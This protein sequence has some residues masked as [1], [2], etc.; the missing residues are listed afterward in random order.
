MVY[1]EEKRKILI[2]PTGFGILA[3]SGDCKD[4]IEEAFNSGWTAGYNSG[5]TQDCGDAIEDAYNSGY[6]SG[7]TDGYQDGYDDGYEKGQEDC[8][9]CSGGTSCSLQLGVYN[10]TGTFDGNSGNILPSE[11]Y[12]GFDSFQV[13]DN[14]YGDKKYDD[15]FQDGLAACSGRPCTLEEGQYGIGKASDLEVTI[16]PFSADGFSS[17]R[18]YDEGYGD[19]KWES[20]YT[21]GYPA[22]YS[23][24]WTDGYNS[25]VTT[26]CGE[27]IETAYNSGYT[28]GQD[29]IMLVSYAYPLTSGWNGNT[30]I[31]PS[32]IPYGYHIDGISEMNILDDG[33]GDWK[34]DSGH[35]AGYGEGYSNGFGQGMAI[36]T[37]EGFNDGYA[38]GSTDGYQSGY[39]VGYAEGL[40]A[41]SSGDCGPAIEEAYQSGQT[42]GYNSGYSAG[43]ADGLIACSNSGAGPGNIN[44]IAIYFSGATKLTTWAPP[45]ER[46]YLCS[47]YSFDKSCQSCEWDFGWTSDDHRTMTSRIGS[48]P[49]VNLN[50][51]ENGL[52]VG[53]DT[54]DLAQWDNDWT[55]YKV[56][57]GADISDAYPDYTQG[58]ITLYPRTVTT[59]PYDAI[60]TLVNITF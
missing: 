34:Y 31:H 6:Q 43:Y 19:G 10:L 2:I 11:G 32:D 25:G 45:S 53:I 16:Y 8:P 42:V 1:Y 28:A 5:V 48:F 49:V 58:G 22:G 33:Y 24:G 47:G 60:Y 13:I 41:C 55:V 3:E 59:S 40:I 9:E 30:I 50:V 20:G 56:V 44:S 39:T 21:A 15:G 18:I 23:S 26:D 51:Q 52:S 7:T 35:T 12:D 46:P 54:N 38:S 27:A 57:F 4:A 37:T 36:G 14:G 17:V 29:S